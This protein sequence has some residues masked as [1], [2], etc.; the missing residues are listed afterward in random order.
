MMTA[1][2]TGSSDA[3]ASPTPG[4]S[5]MFRVSPMAHFAVAFTT[6]GLMIPVL[7]WPLSSPVLI[8]PIVISA[9]IVRLRTVADDRGVTVRS[10]WGSRTVGW[11]EIVG[12]RFERGSWCRAEL[13]DGEDLR[14]PAVTFVTLP[15]LTAVS[16]GRVPNPYAR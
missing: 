9:L 2:S 11:D 6:V 5:A 13:K 8:L 1:V 4:A 15:E 12:L 10:L 3:T 16:A 14:L 7:A